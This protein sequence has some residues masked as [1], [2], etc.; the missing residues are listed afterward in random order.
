MLNENL[1]DACEYFAFLWLNIEE[2]LINIQEALK[3][4]LEP[5]GEDISFGES[6]I[7]KELV[8]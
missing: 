2:A 5:L 4:Y 6:A 7:V 8:L 3:L 1:I